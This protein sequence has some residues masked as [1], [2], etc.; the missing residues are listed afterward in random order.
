MVLVAFYSLGKL[1][2]DYRQHWVAIFIIFAVLNAVFIPMVYCFY[3]ETKGLTLEDIPLLFVKGGFT[4][5]VM[6]SKGGRTV[7][8]HQHAQEK[9]ISGKMVEGTGVTEEIELSR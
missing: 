9:N 3:P 2:S 1:T 4:G 8:P 5:G 7:V 6:S